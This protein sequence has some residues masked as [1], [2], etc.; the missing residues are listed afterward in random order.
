MF[1]YVTSNGL[2]VRLD[3]ER[4]EVDGEQIEILKCYQFDSKLQ[5]MGVVVKERL[6]DGSCRLRS[7]V[8][9]SPEK[10][11]ELCRAESLPE[12]FQRNVDSLT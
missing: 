3:G 10:I 6:D 1:K 12:D 9:G 11:L 7:I 8:K 5:R 2:S 4:I